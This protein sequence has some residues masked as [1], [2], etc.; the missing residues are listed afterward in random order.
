MFNSRDEKNE[1]K[2]VK[3]SDVNTEVIVY[4][5][6]DLYPSDAPEFLNPIRDFHLRRVANEIGS[7]YL[8]TNPDQ[9]AK[10]KNL[11]YLVTDVSVEPTTQ[12]IMFNYINLSLSDDTFDGLIPVA[13][14]GASFQNE[15]EATPV[16]VKKAALL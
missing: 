7:A 15:N 2:S 1:L 3:L 12:L 13:G 4:F 16:F 5:S 11:T 9:N 8:K 14:T 10:Q 6:N